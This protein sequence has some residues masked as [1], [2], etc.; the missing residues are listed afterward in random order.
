MTECKMM[1]SAWISNNGRPE[2]VENQLCSER[3]RMRSK[4]ICAMEPL[5]GFG[6]EGTK[7]LYRQGLGVGEVFLRSIH[8]TALSFPLP[9]A[10][11]WPVL[12]HL[13][14]ETRGMPLEKLS[15]R[16]FTPRKT[17]LNKSYRT[18]WKGENQ[19]KVY[20]L[21]SETLSPVSTPSP[22]RLTGALEKMNTTQERLICDDVSGLLNRKAQPLTYFIKI[23]FK[24]C[25]LKLFHYQ[26]SC[27]YST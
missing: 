3:W 14:P 1:G 18:K 2:E 11:R 27:K 23:V 20:T 25:I 16:V 10:I 21:D 15:Q 19:M 5:K 8:T 4:L 22:P 13:R 7:Y 6:F 9:H 24:L 12:L 17:R 26:K